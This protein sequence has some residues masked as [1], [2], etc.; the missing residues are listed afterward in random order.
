ME[1]VFAGQERRICDMDSMSQILQFIPGGSPCRLGKIA[2]VQCDRALTSTQKN[3]K[4]VY[5]RNRRKRKDVQALST[6]VL[7]GN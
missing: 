4:V 6:A 2:S 5:H 7:A 1:R 3:Q